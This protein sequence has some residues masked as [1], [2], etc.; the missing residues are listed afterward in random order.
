M[1]D[2]VPNPMS[3]QDTHGRS[4]PPGETYLISPVQRALR[5]LET[6]ASG[7][8]TGNVSALA[9][10]LNINRITLKRLLDT[11]EHEGMIEPVAG[12]GGHRI[13]TRFLAMA[14]S[15]L[16]ERDLVRLAQ[17]ILTELAFRT[18]LSAYLTMLSGTDIVYLLQELPDTPLVSNIRVGS[19]VPA[20]FTAPGRILLAGIAP[21]ERRALLGAEPLARATEQTA[22]SHADLEKIITEDEARGCA[23]S[24]SAFERGVTACAAPVRDGA[25]KVIAAISVAGPESGFEPDQRDDIEKA[26]REAGRLLSRMAGGGSAKIAEA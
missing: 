17:P 13:G 24:F 6:I 25:D 8:E 10:R 3:Q 21:A 15:A 18:G 4:A 22:R 19:R 7:G 1:A 20:H 16:G 9:A 14:A 23:W 5:L 2:G 26:V 12:S 11:L